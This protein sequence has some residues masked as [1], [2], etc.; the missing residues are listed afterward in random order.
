MPE[1]GG[2]VQTQVD[3]INDLSAGSLTG[4]EIATANFGLK[5]FEHRIG[6][7][8]TAAAT[9]IAWATLLFMTAMAFGAAFV[10]AL[11]HEAHNLSWHATILV[12]AFVVPPTIILVALIKSVYQPEKADGDSS[13]PAISFLKELAAAIAAVFK[14]AKTG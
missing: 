7:Q 4:D 8:K 11:V 14:A 12:G 9:A 6:Q 13:V 2:F 1:V 10:Y 5:E 3:P